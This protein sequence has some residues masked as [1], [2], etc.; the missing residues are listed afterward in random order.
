MVPWVK[1][2]FLN[3]H[4]IITEL[5]QWPKQNFTIP[6][7]FIKASEVTF[8]KLLYKSSCLSV[9]CWM[10][11]VTTKAT[12]Q[13]YQSGQKPAQRLHKKFTWYIC[14]WSDICFIAFFLTETISLL[15]S[16]FFINKLPPDHILQDSKNIKSHKF[17][18]FVITDLWILLR[19]ML[20]YNNV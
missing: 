19:G 3:E 5:F 6:L 16:Q 18:V 20:Q 2:P 15:F 7:V 9:C 13:K 4:Q 11:Q 10:Y 1:L 8:H 14:H 12:L 17:D